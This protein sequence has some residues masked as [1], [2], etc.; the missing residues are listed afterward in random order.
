MIASDM[1]VFR[2]NL[3]RK[4]FETFGQNA[5][6]DTKS[7]LSDDGRDTKS[8][9]SEKG[10]ANIE[11]SVYNY[12]LEEAHRQKIV[13][14]WENR[15]FCQIYLDRMRSIYINLKNPEFMEKIMNGEF[16]EQQVGFMS[17][18]EMCPERWRLL[19]EQKMKRDQNSQ[20]TT[21]SAST[22]MFTCRKCQSKK[23]V[24]YELQTRSAD[25][26]S[27]IFVTCLNCGKNWKQ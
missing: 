9:L 26:P 1:N 2:Q 6:R 4:L 16:K 24:Y 12:S 11:I 19:M 17:H 20:G 21:L 15:N 5:G 3:R 23:C 14:K 8:G 18:H 13:K 27:T 7:G 10:A 22:D 25:E